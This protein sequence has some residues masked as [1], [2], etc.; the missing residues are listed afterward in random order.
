MDSEFIFARVED[1]FQLSATHNKAKFLGFLS[2]EEA[3]SVKKFIYS[4]RSQIKYSFFGGYESAQRVFLACYPEWL[5][6]PDFPI[7]A[8]T[9]NFRK[10]DKLRHR[11]FL[12][13]LMAL[14]IKREAVGDILIDVG[15][16]V[17]FLSSDIEDY[18]VQNLNTVGRIGVLPTVGYDFPL[19]ETESLFEKTVTVASLRI[20]CVV[21]ACANCSRNTANGFIENG[22]VSINSV[23]CQKNTKL[24]TSG[25]VISIR[26]KGK[27][28]IISSDKKTKKE[29]TVL[30]YRSY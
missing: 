29:R 24:I 30:V 16:A 6:V 22:F 7:T 26:H 18:V 23:I 13:S 20:D 8:V 3:V 28:E 4:R 1:L 15:R 5:E 9:V 10:T 11:D 17:I 21:S 12:G 2:K 25:D 14:G 27:F 19:P